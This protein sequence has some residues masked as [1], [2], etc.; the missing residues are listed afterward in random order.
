MSTEKVTLDNA[1]PYHSKQ[2][3]IIYQT[4]AIPCTYRSNTFLDNVEMI[5]RQ[6]ISAHLPDKD[7]GFLY[8]VIISVLR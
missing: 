5:S 8:Q 1:F 6:F 3:S 4:N 2:C 7:L